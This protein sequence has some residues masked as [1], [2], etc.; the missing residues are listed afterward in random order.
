MVRRL[1]VTAMVCGLSLQAVAFADTVADA[2]GTD[3]DL[4]SRVIHQL[5][6]SD[7][8][9]APRVHVSTANSVVTLE[10]TGLSSAQA[11]KILAVVRAVP[12]VTKVDNRLHLGL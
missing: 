5:S 9:V 7:R 8:D 12:G 2:Q 3:A 11:A 1:L 6:D 10:G 4:T